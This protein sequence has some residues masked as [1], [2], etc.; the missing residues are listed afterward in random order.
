MQQFHSHFE[1]HSDLLKSVM[2]SILLLAVSGCR[3]Q[4]TQ[5]NTVQKMP[6]DKSFKDCM[7]YC[8]THA[9]KLSGDSLVYYA[10]SIFGYSFKI[11]TTGS[12]SDILMIKLLEQALSSE[13]SSKKAAYQL[14]SLYAIKKQY[15]KSISVS[16]IYLNDTT[17]ILHLFY[18]SLIYLKIGENEKAQVGLNFV[19]RKLEW[20]IHHQAYIEH[21]SYKGNMYILSL[22]FYL[23]DGKKQALQNYKQVTEKYPDD[24]GCQQLYE[25][26]KN[27]KN[28]DDLI[29][30]YMR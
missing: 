23:Q 16:N 2:T 18:K 19:R 21:E 28:A 14:F 7:L 12:N 26:L 22:I 9:N 30:K 11:D 1:L 6:L 15:E 29:S 17:D 24:I 13:H 3:P 10:D 27:Y 8:D 25:E 5:N 20:A 4:V